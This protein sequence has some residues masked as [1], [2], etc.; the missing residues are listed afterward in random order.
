MRAYKLSIDAKGP[1]RQQKQGVFIRYEKCHIPSRLAIQ[2]MNKRMAKEDRD[3]LMWFFYWIS[4]C[5]ALFSRC[6]W[7]R[8]IVGYLFFFAHWTSNVDESIGDQWNRVKR[9]QNGKKDN[10]RI[11]IIATNGSIYS[12][13]FHPEQRLPFK[14]SGNVSSRKS[15]PHFQ[16]SLL[17]A[18]T[19][20]PCIRK[21]F[22]GQNDIFMSFNTWAIFY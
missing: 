22:F 10:F 1:K 12:H 8:H 7:W 18:R 9:V 6:F 14:G 3:V 11:P 15:K 2:V 21:F 17:N 13:N 20:R 4:C 5:I 19:K 16:I